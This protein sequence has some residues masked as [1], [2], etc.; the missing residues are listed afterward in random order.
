MKHCPYCKTDYEKSETKC[1]SCQAADYELRCAGC[2][3]AHS[4]ANCPNCKL[5]INESIILCPRC[6]KRVQSSFCVHC[7][8]FIKNETH[9]ST[10][11]KNEI[12]G[13]FS[14]NSQKELRET[15]KTLNSEILTPGGNLL[16]GLHQAATEP[17]TLMPNV[18]STEGDLLKG[19]HKTSSELKG[20]LDN[21]RGCFT[22]V[23]LCVVCII[24]LIII[25]IFM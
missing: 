16:Q 10:T 22:L 5:G 24:V 21:I 4:M 3:T 18:L 6:G 15:L 23:C 12:E 13:I 1:P 25:V 17:K 9:D 7:K 14:P 8:Y 11:S 20:W 2:N 19:F